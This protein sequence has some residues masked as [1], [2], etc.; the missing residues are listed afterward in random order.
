MAPSIDGYVPGVKT[1]ILE[2]L[3]S[4]RC[5]DKGW[6]RW[7][8]HAAMTRPWA[9]QASGIAI[10]LLNRLD[11]LESVPEQKKQQAVLFL[12]SCQDPSDHLF[13]DPLETEADHV[14]EHTWEQIWGQRNG[15]ALSA[16]AILGIE[17]NLSPA[18]AQFA[19]LRQVD[20]Q[21]WT[22]SLD[23][24]NPWRFGESWSRA[25]Q[26]FLAT[27]PPDER[28]DSVPV[29]AAMFDVMES[30]ILDPATGMPT[31]RGCDRDLPRAMAGLFKIMMGY[32]AVGRVVPHAE[33]AIDATLGLQ[34]DNGEFGHRRDMC[35]NWDAL[36]VLRELD[37]QLEYA[38]RHGDIV[39]AGNDTSEV[40]MSQYRKS[41]GGFAFHGEV[42][43]TK[44][45][46]IRLCETPLPISD[47]LGTM[48]CLSCLEYADE[49]NSGDQD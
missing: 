25:I 10:G 20:A 38:Y 42:C 13:K 48:M 36:W 18:R 49:W 46:S 28:N 12:Q 24:R 40:L 37:K 27:L 11:A 21:N 22:L 43:L 32:L 41:D 47:I 23:W 19:D 35:M 39:Q 30:E 14:G 4:V 26:A 16:L 9:L 33:R 15:S 29:L 45:H 34:H 2:W 8:Y 5:P 7:K 44:Y 1:G 17:P 6:G 3:E 31:L